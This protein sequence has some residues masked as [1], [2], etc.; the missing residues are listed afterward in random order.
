MAESAACLFCGRKKEGAVL[1]QPNTLILSQNFVYVNSI[2]KNQHI[3]QCLHLQ[4]CLK[5][6]LEKWGNMHYNVNR[7]QQ[8]LTQIPKKNC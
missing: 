8:E 3:T 1:I 2:V 6:G 4:I 7:K 5:C